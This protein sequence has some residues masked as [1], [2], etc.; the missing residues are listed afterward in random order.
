MF[1]LVNDGDKIV[2]IKQGVAFVQGIFLPYGLT[3]DD[4]TD[5]VREGGFG[6]TDR[7]G[8]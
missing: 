6:S 4:E 7:R 5:G 2:D 3:V 8:E 1:K